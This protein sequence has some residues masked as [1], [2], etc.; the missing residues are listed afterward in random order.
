MGYEE[1]VNT[2]E[3]V[4]RPLPLRFSEYLKRFESRLKI[5]NRRKGKG[6]NEKRK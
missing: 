6:K 1:G 5:K 4:K 3:N 2:D